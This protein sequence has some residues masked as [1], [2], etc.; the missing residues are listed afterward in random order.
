MTFYDGMGTYLRMWSDGEW[1]F[2][3]VSMKIETTLI[4]ML[5]YLIVGWGIYRWRRA[6][7]AKNARVDQG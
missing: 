2:I 7:G 3:S 6:K 4:A 5:L 1:V